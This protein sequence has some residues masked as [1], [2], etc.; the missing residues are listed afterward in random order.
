MELKSEA[1]RVILM[2]F[3][4]RLVSV[5]MDGVDLVQ[6]GGTYAWSPE[7]SRIAL[8]APGGVLSIVR[9]DTATG[10]PAAVTALPIQGAPMWSSD[11]TSLSVVSGGELHVVRADGSGDTQLTHESMLYFVGGEAIPVL[12]P[13]P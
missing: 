10:T 5:I 3:G 7:G 2:P 9:S 13:R 11:G 4:A 1:L 12:R 6:G 8:V